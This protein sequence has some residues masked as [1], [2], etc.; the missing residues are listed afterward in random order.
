MQ[1]HGMHYCGEKYD[2]DPIPKKG[3]QLFRSNTATVER[4]QKRTSAI[5]ETEDRQIKCRNTGSTAYR[6][7]QKV[8]CV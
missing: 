3:R 1:C 5:T 8:C 6:A 2:L 7:K 4:I